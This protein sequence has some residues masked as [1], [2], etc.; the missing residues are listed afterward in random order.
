[1]T[2][3]NVASN[4]VDGQKS[5]HASGHENAIVEASEREEGEEP[6]SEASGEDEWETS[7]EGSDESGSE[8]EEASEEEGISFYSYIRLS[9]YQT[10]SKYWVGQKIMSVFSKYLFSTLF[11]A[12]INTA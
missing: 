3:S 6:A 5:P 2:N 10:K 12:L 1:V 4:E 7:A 9:F 11:K 8:G